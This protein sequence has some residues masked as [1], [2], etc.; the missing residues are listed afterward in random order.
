MAKEQPPSVYSYSLKQMEVPG[1]GDA[2]AQPRVK[3]IL[4]KCSTIELQPQATPPLTMVL[5]SY[6]DWH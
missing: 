6:E 1:E 2:G 5:I 4:V 3:T